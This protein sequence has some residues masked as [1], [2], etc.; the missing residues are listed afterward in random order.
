MKNRLLII[1]DENSIASHIKRGLSG[2]Y[3]AVIANHPEKARQLLSSGAFPVAILDL[4]LPPSPMAILDLGLPP[5]P[6][7]PDEG[8]RLLEEICITA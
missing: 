6:N 4:G 1:E 3:D 5:S 8:F 2:N 7:C